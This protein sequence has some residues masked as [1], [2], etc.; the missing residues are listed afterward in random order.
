MAASW[1]ALA[2][3]RWSDTAIGSP[4]AET[5]IAWATP[6]V[7]LAKLP[8]SQLRLRASALS[9]GIAVLV[10]RRLLATVEPFPEAPSA[11]WPGSRPSAT[12]RP[13][14]PLW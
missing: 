1:S 3:S 12:M 9:C 8:T 7:F 5:T 2:R 14:R 11:R 6:E 10:L 13:L 4:S